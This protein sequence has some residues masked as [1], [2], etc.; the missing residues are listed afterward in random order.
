[1][2]MRQNWKI[3]SLVKYAIETIKT[4]VGNDQVLCGL[5]G[6]VDSSVVA[7]LLHKAIGDN[8]TCIFVDNGLLRAGEREKVEQTFRN[9]FNINL[10]VVDAADRFLNNLKGVSDPE[11]KRKI[12]GN[13]SSKFLKR[14]R[15]DSVVL[16]I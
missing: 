13:T 11:K 8:L 5:S 12:I 2:Q 14:K 7:M 15:N 1:M 6:G 4:Q 10:G 3:D 16:S 9:H